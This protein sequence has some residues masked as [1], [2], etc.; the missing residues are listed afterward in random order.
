MHDIKCVS[1][2]TQKMIHFSLN[3]YAS[4]NFIVNMSFFD[5]PKV[6]QEL[7]DIVVFNHL[8]ESFNILLSF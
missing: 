4:R 1:Y 7:K 2:K 5:C 6:I 8:M 3:I